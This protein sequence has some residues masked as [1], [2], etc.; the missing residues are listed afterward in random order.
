MTCNM[1][2]LR[3]MSYSVK[4]TPQT[5]TNYGNLRKLWTNVMASTAASTN[6]FSALKKVQFVLFLKDLKSVLNI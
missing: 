1:Y 4:K 5:P 3:H 2:F 6:I